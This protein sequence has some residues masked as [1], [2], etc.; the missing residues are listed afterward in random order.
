MHIKDILSLYST[1]TD[2][3]KDYYYLKTLID[4]GFKQKEGDSSP[5]DSLTNIFMHCLKQCQFLIPQL[6]DTI[7]AD[8][9]MLGI[10]F[11]YCL[12]IS[13]ITLDNIRLGN[14]F[15]PLTDIVNQFPYC[16]ILSENVFTPEEAK[17][18]EA[19]QKFRFDT[20]GSV[21]SY[22]ETSKTTQALMK[23]DFSSLLNVK[24]KYICLLNLNFSTYL[25]D[26]YASIFKDLLRKKKMIKQHSCELINSQDETY[27][28]QKARTLFKEIGRFLDTYHNFVA[29]TE[30]YSIDF[31][32]ASLNKLLHAPD[33]LSSTLKQTLLL[34][35]DI[36]NHFFSNIALNHDCSDKLETMLHIPIPFARDYLIN[37]FRDDYGQLHEYDFERFFS[38]YVPF[39]TRLFFFTLLCNE[40]CPFTDS[41]KKDSDLN[42]KL[43]DALCKCHS[44]SFTQA[45]FNTIISGKQKKRALPPTK[46][47]VDPTPKQFIEPQYYEQ[48][49]SLYYDIFKTKDWVSGERFIT[50]LYTYSHS[51]TKKPT[52]TDTEYQEYLI[53]VAK[54]IAE[55]LLLVPEELTPPIKKCLF[56]KV[57]DHTT[58][59]E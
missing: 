7:L 47:D 16:Y 28:E 20:H 54:F 44:L 24:G 33:Y 9:Q 31:Y 32:E 18:G 43:C 53:C 1:S 34:S 48:A 36:V 21:F 26:N 27:N 17:T 14:S 59:N 15:I 11:K 57:I 12:H 46:V 2:A 13:Q 22:T 3:D 49:L 23:E 19:I 41:Y 55:Y 40:N 29:S 25:F 38:I 10:L 45:H 56:E 37:Y 8:Y 58:P 52:Y 39:L 51:L 42:K 30:V 4:I 6:H 5:L 50:K 35:P